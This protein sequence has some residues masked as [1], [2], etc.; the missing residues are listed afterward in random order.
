MLWRSDGE[1]EV[2][3]FSFCHFKWGEHMSQP[4]T[5][6]SFIIMVIN[7]TV[8]FL[9]LTAI[10]VMIELIHAIDPT[11]KP[12]PAPAI[13]PTPAPVPEPTA[14]TPTTGIP[15]EV[16]AVIAAAVEAM[17]FRFA[18]VR[19]VRPVE[20]PGWRDAGRTQGMRN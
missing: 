5:T 16:I 17:G 18:D 15:Q 14:P 2:L 1:N 7:M 13:H 20:R 3:R 10:W 9:V 8:V 4:V 11:K 19:A 6:N 12:K